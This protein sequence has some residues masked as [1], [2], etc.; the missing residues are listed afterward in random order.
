[1]I[2]QSRATLTAVSMLSPT[3]T[4]RPSVTHSKV[5]NLT[6]THQTKPHNT[7]SSYEHAKMSCNNHA[8]AT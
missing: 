4:H 8:T 6:E 3:D 5:K 2:P 1:M 7:T